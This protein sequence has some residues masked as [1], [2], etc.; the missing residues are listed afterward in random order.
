[1]ET[2]ILRVLHAVGCGMESIWIVFEI[3]V[4]MHRL[5][6]LTVLHCQ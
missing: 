6:E 1:M 2:G 4:C 5:Y 3:N